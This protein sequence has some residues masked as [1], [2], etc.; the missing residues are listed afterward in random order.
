LSRGRSVGDVLVI[1]IAQD[2]E[3]ENHPFIIPSAQVVVSLPDCGVSISEK[4][5]TN[6]L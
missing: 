3:G 4:I 2:E 6:F 5:L 1:A